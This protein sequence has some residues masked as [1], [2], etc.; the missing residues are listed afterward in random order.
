[1]ER[2]RNGSSSASEWRI[3]FTSTGAS[4]TYSANFVE[5]DPGLMARTRNSAAGKEHPQR[6]GIDL[7]VGALHAR[8]NENGDLSSHDNVRTLRAAQVLH[9][10]AQQV[11]GL[12]VGHDHAVGAAG[13]PVRDALG[14]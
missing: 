4:F 2:P 10:L 1:M 12:D 13:N 5:V 7:V 14:L 3:F 8:R 6:D 9:G 11:A